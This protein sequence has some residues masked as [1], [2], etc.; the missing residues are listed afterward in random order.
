M[1]HIFINKVAPGQTPI[2]QKLS[3]NLGN[4]IIA[5]DDE[6]TAALLAGDRLALYKGIQGS[7]SPVIENVTRISD[8]AKYNGT[9]QDTWSFVQ[10]GQTALATN[11]IDEVQYLADFA[12]AKFVNLDGISDLPGSFRA[13]SLAKLGPF[14][15][16]LGTDQDNTEVRW[17]DEDDPFVWTPL[18]TNKS[19]DIN[20]RELDSD[21]VTG[22]EFGNSLLIFGRGKVQIFQFLG[23]PF[24]FGA[25]PLIEGLGAVSKQA[26]AVVGRFIYG[27]GP[28]GLFITDGSTVEYIDEPAIHQYIFEQK[29]DPRFEEYVT[30]WHE[31][32]DVEVYF[33]FPTSAT[34]GE[35]VSFN[36]KSRVWSQHN[37][38]RTSAS[39]GGLWNNAIL[40]DN[41]GNIWAQGPVIPVGSGGI[42]VGMSWEADF[43]IGFGMGGF[44]M[45]GFG[46]F[47]EAGQTPP[48]P[49]TAFASIIMF[50]TRLGLDRVNLNASLETAEAFIETKAMDVGDKG[51]TY[52][53]DRFVA[54]VSNRKSQTSLVM[55][56]YGS[57]D[58]EGED[59]QFTLLDTINVA[60]ED[61]MYADPPG[62]RYYKIIFRDTSV[63]ERWRLHGFTVW[64]EA[65]GEEF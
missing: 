18:A 63:K 43:T 58:E 32:N 11:G 10:F 50:L 22:V 19:R 20:L 14:I 53:L 8:G 56:V 35:T 27:F 34:S 16:A 36:P 41:D 12:T 7:A 59:M 21:I 6:G 42:P 33:S 44:A 54:N 37:Y 48:A 29:Y 40:A 28:N 45:P 9:D 57:D 31:P 65:G 24:F 61:P 17:S 4:G 15:I 30:V 64:G 38:W 62:H 47:W 3:G 49:A 60:E 23:P 52:F 39:S 5:I 1:K 25:R 51:F 46:G 2:L 13:K 55:E 26:L